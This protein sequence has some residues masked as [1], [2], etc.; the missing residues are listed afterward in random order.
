MAEQ[1]MAN[2]QDRERE[3]SEKGLYIKLNYSDTKSAC[4][5]YKHRWGVETQHFMTPI[6]AFQIFICL[7]FSKH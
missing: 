6:K 5:S 2:D 3:Q 4:Q 7:R 1:N